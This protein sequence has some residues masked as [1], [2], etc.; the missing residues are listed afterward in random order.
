MLLTTFMKKKLTYV[1]FVVITLSCVYFYASSIYESNSLLGTSSELGSV[2][3]D[4]DTY[5]VGVSGQSIVPIPEKADS[6]AEK[7]APSSPEI[8]TLAGTPSEAEVVRK[9]EESRGRFDEESLKDYAGYDL[10]TL[11]SLVANG[12]VKAM[13][14][15]AR[16]YISEQYAGEYGVK[17]S[18]PL[19]K[20]AAIHGSSYAMELYAIQYEAE[21]FVNGTSDRNVLLETLSWNNAAALRGDVYPNNS[22]TLDLRRKNIQLSANEIQ[23][24]RNRSEEIYQ[25][26]L[27]E[28]KNMGLGDFDN[29]VPV[30]VQKYFA[31]LET[32]IGTKK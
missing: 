15:L 27:S 18:M 31:Y 21:H 6:L 13:I 23:S 14:A 2:V 8:K 29:S 9:W 17:Y 30:E 19:L 11:R 10:D 4:V 20:V 7:I 12:D 5:N 25:Q 26:L 3:D 24:I 16:L 1:F 28:R 22:A 32:Y